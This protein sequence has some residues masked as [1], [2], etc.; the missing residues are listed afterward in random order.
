[1][2]VTGV[3][4]EEAKLYL[5]KFNSVKHAIFSIISGSAII[6]FSSGCIKIK[7]PALI[8]DVA[9]NTMSSTGASFQSIV[10]LVNIINFISNLSQASKVSSL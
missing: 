3:S 10:S 6:V 5:D 1:M 8:F 7:F 4:K 2:D 9:L